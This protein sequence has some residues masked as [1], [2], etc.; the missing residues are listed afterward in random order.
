MP[1]TSSTFAA[2]AIGKAEAISRRQPSQVVAATD[3]GLLVPA[4]G[5]QWDPLRTHRFA[6]PDTSAADRARAL[7]RLAADLR[8]VDRVVGWQEALAV[9]VD[10]RHLA[11]WVAESPPGELATTLHESLLGA[12]PGFWVPAIWRCPECGGKRLADL[13]PDE[14]G[15]R[16]DHWMQ[17]GAAMIGWLAAH[18]DDG[19]ARP[20]G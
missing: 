12:E 15:T 2:N 11:S 8:G 17:L 6:G 14:E 1:E 18:E 5:D 10:G 13:T 3:G 20:S 9:A 19:A 4:L 16:L 7:L